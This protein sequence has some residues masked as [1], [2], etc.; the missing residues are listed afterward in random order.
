MV[1]PFLKG[2]NVSTPDAKEHWEQHYGE[3]GRVWSGRVNVRMAEIAESLAP[4]RALDLGCGEG[5]DAIW[6]AERGWQVVAVDI[7]DTALQRAREDAE[8]RGVAD[9][10]EFDQRDLAETFPGGDYDLV[11]AQFLHSKLPLDRTAIL[12]RAAGAVRQGGT[13]LVV[14]HSGPPP[15]ASKL[16][17]HHDFPSPDEVVKALNL[18]DAE[19][20]QARMDSAEREAKG[21]D[22]EPATWVDNVIVLRRR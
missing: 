17:H 2:D 13:L 7:S 9:R 14:D 3:R 8:T 6:L 22:G 11:S 21:P 4:G 15:W 18:P 10:I 16:D 12:I 20:D 19:W 5:G 1:W